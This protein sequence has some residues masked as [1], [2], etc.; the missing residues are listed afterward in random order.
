MIHLILRILEIIAAIGTVSSWFYYLLCLWSSRVFLRERKAQK[1]LRGASPPPP[2][3]I[4]KPLKGID[5][6]IYE[7]FRSHCRQ[8]YPEYEII[9]ESTTRNDP[10]A[11]SVEKTEARNF[12]IARFVLSCARSAWV[13]TQ[14]SAI[15]RRWLRSHDTQRWS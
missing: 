13:G 11:G 10:A 7:S 2:V 3:S 12:P 9:L 5:P 8:D 4:L 15:W 1:N 14:K 6:E